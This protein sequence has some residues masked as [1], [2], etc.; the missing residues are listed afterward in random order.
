MILPSSIPDWLTAGAGAGVGLG[1]GGVL[2]V[3]L[4]KWLIEY[5]GGRVDKREAAIEA[6][7]AHLD[8]A[9]QALIDH[10]QQQITDQAERFGAVLTRLD[11]VEAELETCRSQH[12]EAEARA[13]RYEGLAQGM[14]DAREAAA[15][16]LASDRL[17]DRGGSG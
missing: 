10:L 7:T 15:L 3:H 8:E 2:A 13:K 4:I 14:G 9:T 5:V 17:A 1:A 12:A 11:H 16:I 6:R